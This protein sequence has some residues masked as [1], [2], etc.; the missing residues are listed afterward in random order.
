MASIKN[1]V[2]VAIMQV[3]VLVAGVLAAGICH[4]VW[5]A[6]NMTMPGP[7]AMLYWHGVMGFL[8]PVGWGLATVMVHLRANISEEI[9]TLM[10]WAGVLTLVLLAAFVIYAD[11]TPWLNGNM[12][13]AAGD[14]DP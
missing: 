12:W 10:F 2:V 4:K 5:T 14:N 11:V 8:V 7:A 6:N 3:G 1:I 9:K 13:N